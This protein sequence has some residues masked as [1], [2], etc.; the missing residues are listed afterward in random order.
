M[1]LL[2]AEPRTARELDMVR[3]MG[4]GL[5]HPRIANRH[6]IRLD[7]VRHHIRSVCRRLQVNPKGAQLA[8][9]RKRWRA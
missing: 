3:G 5:R 6:F 9:A 2:P 4:D 1:S 8:H 7:L